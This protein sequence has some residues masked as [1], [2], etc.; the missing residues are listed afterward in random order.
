MHA[1]LSMGFYINDMNFNELIDVFVQV[2]ERI[3]CGFH[4]S[5]FRDGDGPCGGE[6]RICYFR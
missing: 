2:N 4:S 1:D 6:Q 3:S 5:S